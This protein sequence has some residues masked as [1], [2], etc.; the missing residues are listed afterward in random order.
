M[1]YYAFKYSW[2][3][4]EIGNMPQGGQLGGRLNS[5]FL[6]SLPFLKELKDDIVFDHVILH[7]KAKLTSVIDQGALYIPGILMA[8]DFYETIKAFNFYKHQV[9][10][11]YLMLKGI[12]YKNY[13]LINVCE[14]DLS[15]VNY[16]KSK[17]YFYFG[18][19]AWELPL[20]E[21][22]K[23][24]FKVNKFEDVYPLMNSKGYYSIGADLIVFNKSNIDRDVFFLKCFFDN[25]IIVSERFCEAIVKAKMNGFR[26]EELPFEV[27]FE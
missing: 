2:N 1:K 18:V 21:E 23:D 19:P 6:K 26:I 7:N 8:D 16:L 17:L 5:D 20:K 12:L 24:R 4:K 13:Q 15:H 9:H 27:K 14:E 22:L 25:S 10:K 3:L 11:V